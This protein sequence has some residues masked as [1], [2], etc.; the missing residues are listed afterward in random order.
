[1]RAFTVAIDRVAGRDATMDGHPG[2]FLVALGLVLLLVG[3]CWVLGFS[4]PW[5][6]RLPGDIV[7]KGEH[8]SFYFPVTTCILVSLALTVISWL[9]GRVVR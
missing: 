6:G 7:I 1:M 2:W 3:L 4:I 9:F 5:L 8:G